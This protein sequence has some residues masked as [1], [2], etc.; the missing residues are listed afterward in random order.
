MPDKPTDPKPSE[1]Y[2][3]ITF[4][5]DEHETLEGKTVVNIPVFLGSSFAFFSPVFVVLGADQAMWGANYSYALG[6]FI[7]SGLIF[8]AVAVIIGRFGPGWSFFLFMFLFFM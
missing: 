3:R 5:K 4:A 1:E 7:A 6:G 8:C 2:V